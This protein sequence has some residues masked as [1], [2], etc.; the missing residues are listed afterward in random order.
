MR[1]DLTISLDIYCPP[2]EGAAGCDGPLE[3]L[4]Q[5]MLGGLPS[6]LRPTELKWEEARWDEDNA[7]FVRRG[8]LSCGAFFTASATED[9][10]LLTDFILK[11]VV[12]T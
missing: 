10:L 6:G 8:S 1:L 9:G 12:T 11:G 3:V 7:M 2:E 4:H 5:V